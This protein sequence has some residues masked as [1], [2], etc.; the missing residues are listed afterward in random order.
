MEPATSTGPAITIEDLTVSFPAPAGSLTAL[1]DLSGSVASGELVAVI[2]PNGCGKS[3]LLRAIAGLLPPTAGRIGLESDGSSPRVGD[4]R[5][6]LVFQ[7][8]RLLNWRSTL[9][10]VALPLELTGTPRAERRDAA[11]RA[12]AQVG[13][14]DPAI[15]ALHPRELSGGMQQRVALARSLVTDPSILLLD[16]P[17]SA[18]DALTRD[19]FDVQLESLWLARRRTVVMVTHSV[20]EAIQLADRIWVMSSRPGRVAADIRVTL[21]R[22]RPPRL[23]GDATVAAIEVQVRQALTA[24]HAPELEGWAEPRPEAAA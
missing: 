14:A 21:P 6:G 24:V 18:L 4:G 10:N 16:E 15:Y 11:E 22:P 19:A 23:T 1:A 5:V 9:D 3:T 20:A 2:G 13:L 17:F 7:Q 8:P 12:L